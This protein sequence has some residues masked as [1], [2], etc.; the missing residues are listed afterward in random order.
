MEKGKDLDADESS[1][2]EG[3][4]DEAYRILLTFV[5]FGG[6]EDGWVWTGHYCGCGCGC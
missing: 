2:Q 6:D 4:G 5:V 1:D 3:Y